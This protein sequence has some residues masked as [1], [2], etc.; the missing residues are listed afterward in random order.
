MKIQNASNTSLLIALCIMVFSGNA[1]ANC[2]MDKI[3]QYLSKGFTH[4]QVVTMCAGSSAAPVSSEAIQQQIQLEVQKQVGTQ[5]NQKVDQRVK[6]QM[7]HVQQTGQMPTSASL[8]Q[9]Y[10]ATVLKGTPVNLEEDSLSY[11][12]RE[13]VEYG[14]IDITQLRDK[15]CLPTR[16]TIF[17]DG[18]RVISA[19]KAIPLIREHELIVQGNITREYLDTSRL[20]K[21]KMREVDKQLPLQ[22]SRFNIPVNDGI[23][24]KKVQ[25]RLNRF[26]N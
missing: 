23:D 13:C 11:E 26:I 20:D 2:T 25:A 6:Q 9:L 4:A 16:I 12:T 19:Q 21:Y 24:P 22:I 1:L 18:L 5:V 10:F 17:F 14:E 8:D 3:D 7:Q 15:A